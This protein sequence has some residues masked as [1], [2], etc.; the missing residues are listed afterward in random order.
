MEDTDPARRS[1]RRKGYHDGHVQGHWQGQESRLGTELSPRVEQRKG[2]PNKAKTHGKAMKES[3]ETAPGA[4]PQGWDG[5][6]D[7]EDEDGDQ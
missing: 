1:G 3:W 4:Q 5:G 6:G 2:S 7:V